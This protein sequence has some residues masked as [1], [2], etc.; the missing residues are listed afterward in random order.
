MG[1]GYIEIGSGAEPVQVLV[2]FLGLDL[3][4]LRVDR[5]FFKFI[6]TCSVLCVD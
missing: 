5:N 6:S 1:L 2:I 4:I 3:S